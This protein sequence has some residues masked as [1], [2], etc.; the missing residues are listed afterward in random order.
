MNKQRIGI[1]SFV[2]SSIM[3][4]ALAGCGKKEQPVTMA[5]PGSAPVPANV[6]AAPPVSPAPM[7]APAGPVE[8]NAAAD[9]VYNWRDVPANQ[10]VPVARAA[11]DRGGYQIY[12]TSGETIVVP[13]ENENMYVM[14]FGRSNGD[15][16]YFVN[17]EGKAPLLYVPR[18]GYLSNAAADGAKWYP[19]SKDFNYE[20]P[21]YMGIA[22]SWSAYTG[23]G[24]YPGMVFYG[25]YWG[26]RP[27]YPGFA[28]TPMIGLNINIGGRP[29][30]GWDSYRSYYTTN[31]YN[32]VNWRNS[33]TYNYNSVGRRSPGS[34]SFGS[35]ARSA[36]SFGRGSSSATRTAGSRST[37]SF[38]N[39]SANRNTTASQS[40]GSFG[41]GSATSNRTGSGSNSFGT[42]RNSGSSGSSSF[43]S[44]RSSGSSGTS[45]F[46]GATR[47]RGSF[48]GSGSSGFSGSRSGSSSSSFGRSSS[49]SSGR[50]SSSSFGRSSSSSFGRSSGGRSFGGGRRR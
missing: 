8:G 32:R 44:S 30:Y 13:F 49:G 39:S 7:D 48:G 15:D 47:S 1:I 2:A 34:G 5:P 20:R 23:M 4:S 9:K 31:T 14:K 19:F 11:F 28:Y 24:W 33:N 45:G 17:E 16:M 50:S 40:R 25:G 41:S 42:A 29:Y 6:A 46:S 37:G 43:G 18:N 27:W 35:S 36:G 38:G 12:A 3:V 21:V 10:E 26:Y 22:P